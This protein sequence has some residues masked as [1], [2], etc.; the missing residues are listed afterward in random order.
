M[1]LSLSQKAAN[2]KP[3]A[4]LAVGALAKEM[5]REGKPVIAFSQGEPDFVSPKSA[6]D[7]CIESINI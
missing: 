5:K 3:S 4:T 6:F 2:L 1:S 7:V